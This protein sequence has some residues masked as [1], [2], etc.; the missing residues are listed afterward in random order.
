MAMMY[1]ALGQKQAVDYEAQERALHAGKKK[2]KGTVPASHGL[3]NI[4]DETSVKK[5]DSDSDLP[6]VLSKTSKDLARMKSHEEELQNTSRKSLT[7]QANP[8]R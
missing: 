3:M 5:K 7:D 2:R 6:R 1:E 8:N 4:R